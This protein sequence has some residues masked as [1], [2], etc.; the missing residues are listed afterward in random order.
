MRSCGQVSRHTNNIDGRC[1]S[2]VSVELSEMFEAKPRLACQ[3]GGEIEPVGEVCD[4]FVK[5][6]PFIKMNGSKSLKTPV[7]VSGTFTGV[8]F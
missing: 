7:G 4:K 1:R 8:H 3:A 6:S 5:L 2:A